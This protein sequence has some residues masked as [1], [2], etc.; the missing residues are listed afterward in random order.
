LITELDLSTL[1]D[2][3]GVKQQWSAALDPAS[4][5]Y[6]MYMAPAWLDACGDSGYTVLGRRDRGS[7]PEVTAVVQPAPV[8]LRF[9][10]SRLLRLSV[11]LRAVELLGSQVVGDV[12]AEGLGQTIAAV[13]KAYPR[14]QAV[15]L[16]SVL[17]GAPIWRVLEQEG[18]RLAGAT[19]YL[20]HGTRPFHS[21]KLPATFDEYET[22]FPSKQRY[23][24]RKKVRRMTEAFGG[25][26]EVRRITAV[27]D[28]D[29]LTTSARSVLANS[30]KARQLANPVPDSIERADVLGNLA[31]AGMLR[32][33]VLLAGDQPCAFIVGYLYRGAFHYADLAYCESH[34]AHS[35]GTV[36]LYLVISQL[37]EQDAAAYINFGITDA[38]YK[39]VF[40]NHHAEDAEVLIMKPTL[41]NAL[42]RG[43][44]A[45]FR[46]TKS[47]VR[48]M[49]GRASPA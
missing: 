39:Q 21:V 12:T 47:S 9:E 23:N 40:G 3:A 17:Q 4:N 7:G 10:L 6:C 28:I 22:Q 8:A 27:E 25:A 13:W 16:K 19:A 20:P 11:P 14:A 26:L 1:P 15:Y 18:W 44:H 32:A 43:A 48:A 41:G 5:L 35:P 36:L 49:L 30:W 2:A 31:R 33:F 46:D 24:L 34:A 37:I 29:F 45:M 42:L 38:Q